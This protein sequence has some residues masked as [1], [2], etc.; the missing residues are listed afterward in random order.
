VRPRMEMKNEP[1]IEQMTIIDEE[2]QKATKPPSKTQAK[3]SKEVRKS[4][5]KFNT[6]GKL[7]DREIKELQRTHKTIFDWVAPSTKE[8]TSI[9]RALETTDEEGRELLETLERE[10]RLSR[11]E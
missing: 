6:R 3:I 9:E 5:F 10:E 1:K 11:M 8:E 4:K 2:I 7:K